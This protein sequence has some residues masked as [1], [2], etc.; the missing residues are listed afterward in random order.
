MSPG[1]PGGVSFT[2]S[3]C[4][5][6]DGTPGLKAPKRE[7]TR[8]ERT[9]MGRDQDDATRRDSRQRGW[10]DPSTCLLFDVPADGKAAHG[11]AATLEAGLAAM[12]RALPLIQSMGQSSGGDGVLE[13]A[14]GLLFEP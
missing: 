4:R 1:D 8:W 9:A 5:I 12:P 7:P 11:R 13:W 14:L 6:F 3:A 2:W 10:A